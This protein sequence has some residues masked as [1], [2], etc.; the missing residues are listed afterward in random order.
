MSPERGT[1]P[2]PV[3]RGRSWVFGDDIN[4]DLLHP[5]QF[6]SLA[7]GRVRRGLFHGL[8]PQLIDRIAPGDMVIAGRNFGCGSSRETCIRSFKLNGI[9]AVIAVD[10]AR[11][12]FRNATNA[13]LPCLMV[14][15]SGDCALFEHG[16]EMALGLDE[17]WMENHQGQRARL[18]SPGP[19]VRRI[20]QAGGLL[21]TM[22]EGLPRGDGPQERR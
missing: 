13:G 17:A 16:G 10:F 6:F 22:A 2:A 3:L 14:A 5:P 18:I 8:D 9:A 1:S 19:F 21:E 7:P 11:I 12:F 4:T 20:W 15:D